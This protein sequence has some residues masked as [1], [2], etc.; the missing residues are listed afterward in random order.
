ME[1][2]RKYGYSE[3]EGKSISIKIT[4]NKALVEKCKKHHICIAKTARERAE[5][6]LR[7]YLEKLER[8]P[9]KF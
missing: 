5:R 8:K 9:L 6:V 4:L 2:H 7:E 3:D 1:R